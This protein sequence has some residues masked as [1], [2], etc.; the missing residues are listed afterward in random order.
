MEQQYIYKVLVTKTNKDQNGTE[1]AIPLFRT[2]HP[3]AKLCFSL[4]PTNFDLGV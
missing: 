4:H 2:F 1:Q 3:E